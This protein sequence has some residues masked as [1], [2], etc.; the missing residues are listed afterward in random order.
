[1]D[2]TQEEV[3]DKVGLSRSFVSRVFQTRGG[4]GYMDYLTDMRL[5]KARE[6]LLTTDFSVS[7]VFRQVGYVSRNNYSQKF[8]DFFGVSASDMRRNKDMEIGPDGRPKDDI[9]PS[10]RAAALV[11]EKKGK[12]PGKE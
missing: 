7:D 11:Q 1:M 6:L 5:K 2:L 12:K 3:A 4:T 9:T 8:K 10:D